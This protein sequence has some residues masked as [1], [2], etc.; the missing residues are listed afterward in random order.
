MTARARA[1]TPALPAEVFVDTSAFYAGLNSAD[2][3]HGPV[4]EVLDALLSAGA[5]LVTT[6]FV[7]IETIS[8]LQARE[9]LQ[10]AR[11][12]ALGMVPA[13]DVAWVEE[14]LCARGIEGWVGG[15]RRDLSLVDCVSFALMREL[16]L[17]HALTL[18]RHFAEQG[19]TVIP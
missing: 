14:D 9:G 19:F 18:D 17:G 4:A 11:E 1:D 5:T 2:R 6:S 3:N 16:R 10:A 15:A 13:L 7:L 8:L 12:F